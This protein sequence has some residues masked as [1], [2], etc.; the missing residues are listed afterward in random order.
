MGFLIAPRTILTHRSMVP[1]LP[2]VGWLAFA[3]RH[4]TVPSVFRGAS[5]DEAS[6]SQGLIPFAIE[7][8]REDQL[9][10]ACAIRFTISPDDAADFPP[11][12]V[13][14]RRP[15]PELQ[16]RK[17]CALG[18][19]MLTDSR[20][21]PTVIKRIMGT[22]DQTLRVQ[23]GTIVQTATDAPLD[24]AHNCF[25]LEGNAGSP[26]VDLEDGTVLGMHYAAHYTPGPKGLK[27][28]RAMPWS[29]LIDS[30]FLTSGTETPAASPPRSAPAQASAAWRDTA[31][32][33]VDDRPDNNINERVGL[34]RDGTFITLAL[35]TKDAL[36]ALTEHRF[37][38][39]ISD[40]GRPEG[41]LAGFDLLQ[42]VRQGS[43]MPFAIYASRRA[44]QLADDA[45]RLGATIST[46]RFDRI[47]EALSDALDGVSHAGL[48]DTQAARL[49][50]LL[51]RRSITG[52]LGP[53]ALIGAASQWKSV[54][55]VMQ[56]L[57][58][59]APF[60]VEVVD[61]IA[62]TGYCQLF[63]VKGDRIVLAASRITARKVSYSEASRDG[64]IGRVVRTGNMIH[65]PDVNKDSEYIPAET[66]TRSELAI[67][68]IGSNAKAIGVINIELPRL[69]AFS[70]H[71]AK[72][73]AE[74]A[75]TLTDHLSEFGQSIASQSTMAAGKPGSDATAELNA[76]AAKLLDEYRAQIGVLHAWISLQYQMRRLRIDLR[77]R[78]VVRWNFS[79]KTAP[80]ES[81]SFRSYSTRCSSPSEAWSTA[82]PPIN[83][84]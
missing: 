43:K 52:G 25:T 15:P 19:P 18:Y 62:N 21:D 33:W 61:A 3:N 59:I 2:D 67:P 20:A 63:R 37:D 69:S 72:W 56:S 64:V 54:W 74:F 9:T 1:S 80:P 10:K 14:S 29:R 47:V 55:Q 23:P 11:P 22:A 31:I 30:P 38:A 24:T 60:A 16:G 5:L 34:E 41:K 49:R 57:D 79:E 53:D 75:G 81:K 6:R 27:S 71:Q 39:I 4:D 84:H 51:G 36:Q 78:T 70:G 26:L 17:V 48:S 40:L 46:D 65:L 12:L 8:V 76:T 42:R 13:W 32:L 73:L 28:G 7:A 68:I 82:C 83:S 58:R 35:T 77:V 44:V 45:K 50:D 66:S